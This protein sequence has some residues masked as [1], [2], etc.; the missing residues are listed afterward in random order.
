MLLVEAVPPIAVVAQ[1]GARRKLA[2]ARLTPIGFG[3]YR[4]EVYK[5]ACR[6]GVSEEEIEGEVE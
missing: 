5:K 4:D 2:S 3:V 1:R 6:S